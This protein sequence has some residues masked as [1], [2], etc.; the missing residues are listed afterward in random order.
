MTRTTEGRA[1]VVISEVRDMTVSG[2]D[3]VIRTVTGEEL[4]GRRP[5]CP[6]R[7]GTDEARLDLA[8]ELTFPASDPV[9]VSSGEGETAPF[10][11]RRDVERKESRS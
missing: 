9:A 8:L 10:A 3:L 1:C 5:W 2:E 7:G 6:R 11:R 4:T